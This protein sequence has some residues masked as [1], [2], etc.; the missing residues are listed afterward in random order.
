MNSLLGEQ[1][2]VYFVNLW[3]KLID[4]PYY[5]MVGCTSAS[6]VKIVQAWTMNPPRWNQICC[7]LQIAKAGKNL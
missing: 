6:L 7:A 5:L 2:N 3:A 4:I 1:S